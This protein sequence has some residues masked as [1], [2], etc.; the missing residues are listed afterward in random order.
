[1]ELEWTP[2]P[3]MPKPY[4]RHQQIAEE[5][6]NRPG[7]WAKVGTFDNTRYAY[8]ITRAIREGTWPGKNGKENW[9]GPAGT[10][11]A[12]HIKHDVYARYVGPNREHADNG[13][14]AP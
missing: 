2:P 11:E 14:E 8:T 6:R 4:R 7:Q 10:Y 13:E 9:Y 3:K 5:L 1:M 12:T